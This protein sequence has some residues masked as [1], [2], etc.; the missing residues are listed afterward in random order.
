MANSN[1]P[2]GSDD[3]KRSIAGNDPAS[4]LDAIK[5]RL[6]I[7]AEVQVNSEGRLLTPDDPQAAPHSTAARTVVR[8]QRWFSSRRLV[9]R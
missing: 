3:L 1:Q 4:S 2:P 5:R 9:W 6:A 7:A 8:P